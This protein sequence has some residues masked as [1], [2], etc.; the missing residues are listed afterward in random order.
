MHVLV[1]WWHIGC[2]FFFVSPENNGHNRRKWG[3]PRWAEKYR[4]RYIVLAL[5]VVL[6][7]R[8]VHSPEYD[9]QR[10]IWKWE[11][12]AVLCSFAIGLSEFDE[13]HDSVWGAT[14]HVHTVD[15][16][17]AQHQ[18]PFWDHLKYKFNEESALARYILAAGIR[19]NL[20][21]GIFRFSWRAE[22][23]GTTANALVFL[24]SSSIYCRFDYFVNN[25]HSAAGGR[26]SDLQRDQ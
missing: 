13:L 16:Y 8:H 19:S 4:S 21:R 6:Y 10:W 18:Y 14:S 9:S 22:I 2:L 3:E 12:R 15:V 5:W 11:R 17:G 25:Q 24:L 7:E 23:A 20:H 1:L 26:V